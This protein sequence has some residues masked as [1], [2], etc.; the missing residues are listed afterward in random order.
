MA[1]GTIFLQLTAK[2]LLSILRRIASPLEHLRARHLGHFR[3]AASRVV[4]NFD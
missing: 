4:K 2:A 3:S 1:I